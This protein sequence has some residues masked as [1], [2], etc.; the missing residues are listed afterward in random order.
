[1]KLQLAKWGNSYAV[2]IPKKLVEEY[3]LLEGVSLERE[4]EGILLKPSQK[5]QLQE[6]L[7]G[8]QRQK[9]VEW[10]PRRGKEVW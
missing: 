5:Q 10:G 1:M 4:E 8:M 9:E 3:S 6:L 2:R 7:A